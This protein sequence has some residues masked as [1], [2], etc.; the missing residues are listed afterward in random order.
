MTQ[1]GYSGTLKLVVVY[2][3]GV[4][5]GSVIAPLFNPKTM[6]LGASAGVYALI[7]SH[8]ATLILNWKE[9]GV[10]YRAKRRRMEETESYGNRVAKL[11]KEYD[12][13]R[14]SRLFLIIL[15]VVQDLGMA[16]Y[17]YHY[18]I[19]ITTSYSGML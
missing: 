7:A 10:V 13:I 11:L 4:V 14:L 1:V 16:I 2:T 6:L 19:D 8:L 18:R 9:D 3:S 12:M 15:W 17:N 5:L